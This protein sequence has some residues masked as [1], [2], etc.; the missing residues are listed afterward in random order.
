MY[1]SYDVSMPSYTLS[2][3]AI[4]RVTIFPL[5]SLAELKM[6][7]NQADILNRIIARWPSC[8][9]DLWWKM[10]RLQPSKI[11]IRHIFH[12]CQCRSNKIRSTTYGDP[13]LSLFDIICI[14][15]SWLRP[16]C[17]GQIS[18]LQ[19]HFLFRWTGSRLM[20]ADYAYDDKW[21]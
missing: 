8:S 16:V 21:L 12:Y 1:A 4:L 9:C 14:F 3:V 19:N 15:K 2:Y 5:F 17:K 10:Y 18:R 20:H 7:I 13:S 6:K 11:L